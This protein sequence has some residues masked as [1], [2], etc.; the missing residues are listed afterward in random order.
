MDVNKAKSNVGYGLGYWHFAKPFVEGVSASLLGNFLSALFMGNNNTKFKVMFSFLNS[1][2]FLF[3]HIE[4]FS[5]IFRVNCKF[6]EYLA[7]FLKANV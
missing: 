7:L 3:F 2:M 5:S 6:H 4:N 1:S